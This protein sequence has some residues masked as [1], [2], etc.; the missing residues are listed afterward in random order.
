RQKIEHELADLRN[1]VSS[2]NQGGKDAA[3]KA[4]RI[5][6]LQGEIANQQAVVDDLRNQYAQQSGEP[7]Q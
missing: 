3:Q 6:E 4:Q 5:Q 2:M 7:A 1:E